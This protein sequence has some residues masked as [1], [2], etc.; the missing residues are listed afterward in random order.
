MLGTDLKPAARFKAVQ[1]YLKLSGQFRSRP[2]RLR[3]LQT[4]SKPSVRTNVVTKPSSKRVAKPPLSV[5]NGAVRDPSHSDPLQGYKRRQRYK[6][7]ASE[8]DF[9][10]PTSS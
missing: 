10:T 5:E 1:T 6:Y 4:A 9:A 3:V 2:D 7:D 8:L